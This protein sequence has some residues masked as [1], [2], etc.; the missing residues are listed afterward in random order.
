MLR[1]RNKLLEAREATKL[2]KYARDSNKKPYTLLLLYKNRYSLDMM[3]LSIVSHMFCKKKMSS[4]GEREA[5][6]FLKS[7]K[8]E[9]KISITKRVAK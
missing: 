7:K 5:S 9:E 8:K 2:N 1:I 3:R 4:S 6:N